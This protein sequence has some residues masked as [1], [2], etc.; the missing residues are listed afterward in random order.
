MAPDE[1]SDAEITEEGDAPIAVELR[2]RTDV[3]D[4][5]V[6]RDEVRDKLLEHDY[7]MFGYCLACSR[8]FDASLPELIAERGGDCW[9]IGMASLR[10]P[11]CGGLH[12]DIRI[13]APGYRP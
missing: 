3:Q 12:T 5:I 4:P 6:C 10:C 13:T 1:L 8:S 2:R 11:R 7:G 9:V